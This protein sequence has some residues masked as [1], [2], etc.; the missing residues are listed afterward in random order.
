MLLYFRYKK[1][2]QGHCVIEKT[3]VII[4]VSVIVVF[5]VQT[6]RQN[7]LFYKIALQFSFSLPTL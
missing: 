6:E 5:S 2:G 4:L 1:L 7:I 3:K